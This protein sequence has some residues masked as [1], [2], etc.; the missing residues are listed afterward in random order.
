MT[1]LI[2]SKKQDRATA[3]MKLISD[4]STRFHL[5]TINISLLLQRVGYA[6]T[7]FGPLNEIAEGFEYRP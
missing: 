5:G 4:K 2:E 3:R 1:T 7:L 6:V